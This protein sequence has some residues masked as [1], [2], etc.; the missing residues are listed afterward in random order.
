MSMPTKVRAVPE[1]VSCKM[2]LLDSVPDVSHSP[3]RGRKHQLASVGIHATTPLR[4]HA[5][6]SIPSL[7]LIH[8]RTWLLRS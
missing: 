1:P 4:E 6:S 7:S 2:T 5:L 8:R 3:P